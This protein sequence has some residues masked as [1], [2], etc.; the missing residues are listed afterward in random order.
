MAIMGRRMRIDR[1]RL[2]RIFTD[3]PAV[4]P[5]GLRQHGQ[6]P[7]SAFAPKAKEHLKILAP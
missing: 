6:A 2:G 4:R 3:P 1:N 5:G 7:E